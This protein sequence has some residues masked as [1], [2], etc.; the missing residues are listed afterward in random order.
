VVGSLWAINNRRERKWY[1]CYLLLVLAFTQVLEC[2][3]VTF[4]RHSCENMVMLRIWLDVFR[5][6]VG[7]LEGDRI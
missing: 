7:H 5:E 6:V 4:R 1:L 3:S 2:G